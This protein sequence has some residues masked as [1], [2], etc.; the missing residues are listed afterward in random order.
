MQPVETVRDPA[1]LTAVSVDEKIKLGKLF[2]Y[3]DQQ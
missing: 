1:I 2:Q 3:S